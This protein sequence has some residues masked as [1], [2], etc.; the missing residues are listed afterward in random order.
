M[1]AS[2]ANLLRNED[3]VSAL[4]YGLIAAIVSIAGAT[5]MSM[6]GKI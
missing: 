1:R 2:F 5:V 3:G 6:M 4:E